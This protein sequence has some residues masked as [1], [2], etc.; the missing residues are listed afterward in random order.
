MSKKN[1]VTHLKISEVKDVLSHI[2]SNNRI[3]EKQN[4]KKNSILI[5]SEAGIGK[6]SIVNQLAQENNLGFVKINLSNVEQAGD[7]CGFPLREFETNDHKWVNE[8]ELEII[9][10]KVTLS[11]KTRTSYCPPA[12]VPTDDKG[13]VLLLDD[14]TRAPTHIMQA[15]MEI[16][17]RGEFIS[18]KLPKDCHVFL[19]SNPS[20]EGDYIVTSLDAA[21]KT[22]FIRLCMKFDINE[23]ATWAEFEGID[24]RCIN[25]LLMNPEMIKGEVNAR[26]ATDYF[27]AI[28]SLP[29][30]E[31]EKAMNIIGLLGEGSVGPEFTQ[32][33]ILFVNNKMDKIPSPQKIMD[34]PEH[35]I[36]IKELNNCLGEVGTQQYKQ[37]IASI[38]S[39]RMINY[40]D[41]MIAEKTFK[42][43]ESYERIVSIIKSSVFSG[44]INFNL[45]KTLNT[46]R[47]FSGFTDD[48]ELRKIITK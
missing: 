32:T 10:H 36:A 21:Q 28:S 44:D 27:N 11:G 4:K 19:T 3:L 17:D 12:W 31:T 14:F 48:L 1:N 26:L 42:K 46:R 15:V 47:Q 25:F 22:R 7:L 24:S 45:L 33:F 39:T 5:E 9:G 8:K 37:N 41:K 35:E 20:D 13:V 38:L 40:V 43:K 2:I 18:W 6:T 29:N 30:F 16:I 34:A 23:W